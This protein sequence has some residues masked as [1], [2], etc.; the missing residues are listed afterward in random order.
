[1]SPLSRG[2]SIVC[3]METYW[4]CFATHKELLIVFHMMS[5]W[6]PPTAEKPNSAKGVKLNHWIAQ[7][8]AGAAQA[9]GSKN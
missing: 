1:M 6:L 7:I 2:D 8:N 5:Q 3:F 4:N 9:P